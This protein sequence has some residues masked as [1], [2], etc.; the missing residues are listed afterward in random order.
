VKVAIVN[1]SLMVVET[2][3]RT[4]I[5]SKQHEVIWT[6]E[7]GAEA[8]EKARSTCPDIILMDIEMPVMDGVEATRRIMSENACAILIV[9]GTIDQR[10]TQVFQCLGAG[11]L[12]VVKLS[13][14]ID[15]QTSEGSALIS[16]L[17]AL[18]FILNK[19]V[20][21]VATGNSKTKHCQNLVLIGASAG[22]PSAIATLLA[23]LPVDIPAGIV[24]VQHIDK[25]FVPSLVNWLSD[26]SNLPVRLACE[27]DE[28]EI[29]K[30][31]VAGGDRH[32]R[33]ISTSRLGY[34]IEPRDCHYRPS[35]DVLFESASRFWK[36]NIVGVLLT[37]MGRDGA[38][39]L[40]QLSQANAVTIAQD[41]ASSAVY[42]MPKAAAALGAAK[43]ILDLADIAPRIEKLL[44][45]EKSK[46][47]K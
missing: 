39:G 46:N 3:R 21:V 19:K 43:E 31:L 35:I 20:E 13:N 14:V 45:T 12:D 30:V 16:K 4:L 28:P 29:G 5:A 44:S 9:T 33:F 40:Q 36:G 18:S 22:G 26:H 2:L 11:A 38:R 24:V 32:L 10:A 34:T 27:G 37:G 15:D 25:Q 23:A 8:V 41:A 42:G 7:N 1:D 17:K 6:A 47:S